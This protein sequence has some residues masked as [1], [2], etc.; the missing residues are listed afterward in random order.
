MCVF[1]VRI[2]GC[3]ILSGGIRIAPRSDQRSQPTPQIDAPRVAAQIGDELRGEGVDLSLARTAAGGRTAT[4]VVLVAG[5]TRTIVHDAAI[6]DA[7]PL[8]AEELCDAAEAEA[9]S[10]AADEHARRR[11]LELALSNGNGDGGDNASDASAAVGTGGDV[12]DERHSLQSLPP[13]PPLAATEDHGDGE[14]AR[15][16]RTL[17]N[18]VRSRGCSF[19]ARTSFLHPAPPASTRRR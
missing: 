8:S 10:A 6:N 16:L 11:L 4:S 15:A 2:C 12:G 19:R 14:V 9:A 17:M 13:R 3:G 18:D 5:A 7:A 1:C